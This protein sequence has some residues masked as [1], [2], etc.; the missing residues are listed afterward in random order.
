MN[1]KMTQQVTAGTGILCQ[2]QITLTQYPECTCRDVF[3]IANRSWH[4][5]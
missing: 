4:Q 2:N 1:V 3:K 5:I